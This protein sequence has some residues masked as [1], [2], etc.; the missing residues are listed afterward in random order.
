MENSDLVLALAWFVPI[1]LGIV[2]GFILL[3][4]NEQRS[5]DPA[6]RVPQDEQEVMW[7]L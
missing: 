4:M 6:R 5:E 3:P 2:V 1:L 7:H